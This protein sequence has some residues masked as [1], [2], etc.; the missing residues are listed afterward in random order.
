[1][2]FEKLDRIGIAVLN[3][4]EAMA[5]Y[6]EMMDGAYYGPFED[7]EVGIDV[8]LPRRLGLEFVS[9]R[10][11]DDK[12]GITEILKTKGECVTAVCWKVSDI[13]AAEKHLVNKGLVPIMKLSRCA[14][15]EVVFAPCKKT[16]GLTV[17]INEYPHTDGLGIENCRHFGHPI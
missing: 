3:I 9:P 10:R 6:A 4:E 14:M 1:M 17:V 5:D 2:L 15:K 13:E 16:H 7:D 11:P 8:A 12:I